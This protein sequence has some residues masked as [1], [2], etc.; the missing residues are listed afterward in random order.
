MVEQCRLAVA[1]GLEIPRDTFGMQARI[2]SFRQMKEK[3]DKAGKAHPWTCLPGGASVA[4]KR[5]VDGSSGFTS[6]LKPKKSDPWT[7][8]DIVSA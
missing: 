4:L 6:Q 5:I 2:C 3:I 8:P 7:F 1:D